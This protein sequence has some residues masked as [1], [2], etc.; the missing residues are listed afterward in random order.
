MIYLDTSVL[1]TALTTEPATGRVQLWLKERERHHLC[2]SPWVVTEMQSA[3]AM[4]LRLGIIVQDE[5]ERILDE[6]GYLQ[7]TQ[8][9]Q[10]EINHAHFR[11]AG[12]Y[13]AQYKLALRAPDALHLA[14]ASDNGATLATLDQRMFAAAQALDISSEMP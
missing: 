14:I 9:S 12:G 6:F 1:V 4:K 10:V 11:A 13:A 8:F 3:L 5:R 2:I 7:R